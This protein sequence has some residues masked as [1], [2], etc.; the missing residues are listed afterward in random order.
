MTP[1]SRWYSFPAMNLD[2]PALAAPRADARAWR[3]WAWRRWRR[4]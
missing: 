4:S 2:A 3:A 1:A